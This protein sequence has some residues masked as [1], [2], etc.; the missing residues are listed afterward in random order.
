MPPLEEACRRC[1]S[2][3]ATLMTPACEAVL[4]YALGLSGDVERGLSL[5]R[6]GVDQANAI[7]FMWQ[8][9]LRL[10]GKTACLL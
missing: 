10:Q 3:Q 6:R 5:L 1:V 9:P 2:G 8:Q 4:G 7:G